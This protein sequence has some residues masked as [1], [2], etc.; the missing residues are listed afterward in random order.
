MRRATLVHDKIIEE[1][2]RR[3]VYVG[4]ADAHARVQTIP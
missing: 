4:M 2:L 1:C 3:I